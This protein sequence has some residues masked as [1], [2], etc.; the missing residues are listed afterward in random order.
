[1][2]K[3][4]RNLVRRRVGEGLLILIL[5]ASVV[6]LWWWVEKAQR[7]AMEKKLDLA[8]VPAAAVRMAALRG[9]LAER[10]NDIERLRE[11]VPTRREIGEVVNGLGELGEGFGLEIRVVSVKEEVL[12]DEKGKEREP[13]GP[14][15]LVRFVIVGVGPPEELLEFLHSVEHL[16]YLLAVPEW[17]V[18]VDTGQGSQGTK[19]ASPEE[20]ETTSRR[21]TG[22][23]N[24][25]VLLS[26]SS[27]AE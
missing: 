12:V 3:E 19:A 24:M 22:Q 2:D 18:A 25:S 4:I 11:Y 27:Q 14:L 10:S 21:V 8:Q 5:A 17:K 7:V 26:I 13:E 1:M 9:Q 15:R 6:W 16:P 20:D 23:L